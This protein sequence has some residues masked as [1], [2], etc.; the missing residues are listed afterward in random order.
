MCSCS[1]RSPAT[2][3][4]TWTGQFMGRTASGR[5]LSSRCGSGTACTSWDRPREKMAQ[6]AYTSTKQWLVM[7]EKDIT[8]KSQK[9]FRRYILDREKPPPD[10]NLPAATSSSSRREPGSVRALLPAAATSQ[11]SW[12]NDALDDTVFLPIS[13]SQPVSVRS[14]EQ[15]PLSTSVPATAEHPEQT[16]LRK[17]ARRQSAASTRSPCCPPPARLFSLPLMLAQ[18]SHHRPQTARLRLPPPCHRVTILWSWMA[19]CGCGK[20]PMASHLQTSPG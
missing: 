8:T 10:S 14:P 2:S 18:R 1:L 12:S 11:L 19:G 5:S 6:E 16:P 3:R 17:R 7:K 9:C 13:T 4:S 20:T 15:L